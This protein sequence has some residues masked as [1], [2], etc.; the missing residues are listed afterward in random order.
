MGEGLVTGFGHRL[1]RKIK[2]QSSCP[3]ASASMSRGRL[4]TARGQQSAL[5]WGSDNAGELNP[6]RAGA[7]GRSG[8]MTVAAKI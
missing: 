3:K 5:S 7:L 4:S 8:D 6:G 2:K 1:K